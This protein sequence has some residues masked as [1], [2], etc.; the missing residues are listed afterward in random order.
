MSNI[1]DDFHLHCASLTTREIFLHNHYSYDENPGVEHKMSTTFIK[2]LRAFEKDSSDPITIHMQSLGGEWN[3]GMAIYDTIKMCKSKITII[4]YGQAESMSSI[5]LQAATKRLLTK[6]SYVMVHY[7]TSGYE[8][9]YLNTQ[10]WHNYA[11]RL[12]ETM[13]DIYSDKCVNGRLFKE[14]KY[15]KDKVKKFL[16]KKFKDGDWYMSS[17]EAVDYGFADGVVEKWQ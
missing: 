15:D 4:S 1:L 7:G 5:I 12:C 13:M 8:S 3:E 6:N 10:N 11:K 16:H 9:Q 14:K 2:N 17:K